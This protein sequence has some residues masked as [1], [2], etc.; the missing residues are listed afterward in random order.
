M[1][2]THEEERILAGEQGPVLQKVLQ[3]LVCYGDALGATRFVD[4]EHDGH[5]SW[6]FAIPGV[7]LRLEMLEEIV[8]AGLKTKRPFTLDPAAPLDFKNLGLTPDQKRDF[9]QTFRNQKRY[10]E[11]MQAL[12]LRD[13]DAYTCTPYLEEV[14]NIP[15]R[16]EIL[17]WSE[18]SAVVYANSVIG[19][20]TARNAAILDLF[21]NILGKTPLAGLLTDEG[22]R[23]KWQ[24]ELKTTRLPNPQLLGAAVGKRVLEDVPYV[25]GLDRFLG[26]ELNDHTRDYLKEFGAACAAIGAVGLYHVENVTPEAKEQ[27]RSLLAPDAQ[28]YTIDD[29]ELRALLASY[30]VM[31]ADK[32]A[33][34]K[35]CLIGCPHVSL[36]ELYWWT[37]NIHNTLQA[38]GRKKIAV[39]TVIAAAPQVLLKFKADTAAFEQLRSTGVKLSPTCAEACMASQTLAREAVVTNSNKLRAFTT[40]RLFLDEDLLEIIATGEIK[41]EYTA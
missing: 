33:A 30:S 25:I 15:R 31:W 28:Q 24:V 4:V 23:A 17:A 9:Q 19:A 27:G 18:S 1:N 6:P 2:L 10:D 26:T 13:K 14:G 36:R 41:K 20:R 37:E 35:K 7:G 29:Q 40:A 22:R 12:G 5:F 39:P 8:A 16:G 21:S 34:P 38:Q 3:T 32:E 11:L